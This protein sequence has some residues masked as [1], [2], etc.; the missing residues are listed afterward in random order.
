MTPLFHIVLFSPSIPLNVGSV[1]RLA[2]CTNCTLHLIRPFSFSLSEKRL[3]RAGL[4]YWKYLKLHVHE[5]FE[6]FWEKEE[7]ERYLFASVKGTK[8]IYHYSFSLGDYLIFGNEQFGFPPFVY[9][10]F[11][12]FLYKIPMPGEHAR[13]LNLA[14]SV[15][16]VVYEGIR[17]VLFTSP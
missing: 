17:Q 16:I 9:Q 10:D 5:S 7:P 4:D 2:V 15:A 8:N 6:A 3:R 12:S 13:S 1:A 14:N 11:A